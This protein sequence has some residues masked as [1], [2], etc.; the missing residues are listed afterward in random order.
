MPGIIGSAGGDRCRKRGRHHGQ[1]QWQPATQPDDL[2]DIG[3]IHTPGVRR[4]VRTTSFID[5]LLHGQNG[6]N[7]MAPHRYGAGRAEPL[8]IVVP[9]A[10]STASAT[11]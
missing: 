10:D 1:S 4:R 3:I 8:I 11:S 5:G 7:Y 9:F 6:Y 2:G